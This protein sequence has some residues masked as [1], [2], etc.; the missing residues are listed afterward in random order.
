MEVG[1][2]PRGFL[3]YKK[4]THSVPLN[5]APF[6]AERIANGP[7]DV[8]EHETGEIQKQLLEIPNFLKDGVQIVKLVI[9]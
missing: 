4:K 8:G 2:I 7:D 1:S 3:K 5:S 9:F 6:C